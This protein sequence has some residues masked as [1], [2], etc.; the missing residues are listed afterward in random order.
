MPKFW[1]ARSSP[2]VTMFQPK[3]PLAMWSIVTEA[4][5]NMNGGQASVDIVGTTPIREV[6]AATMVA[7][8]TGSCLGTWWPYFNVVSAVPRKASGT[9]S[10]SS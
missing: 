7:S 3:R 8:G 4:R 1:A 5:A 6:I 9:S 2:L 10:L